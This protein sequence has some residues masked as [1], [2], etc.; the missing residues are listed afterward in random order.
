M[1]GRSKHLAAEGREELGTLPHTRRDA[2]APR[3]SARSVSAGAQARPLVVGKPT[4]VG[5]PGGKSLLTGFTLHQP[6]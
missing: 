4:A 3:L 6:N 2:F 1:R 5:D